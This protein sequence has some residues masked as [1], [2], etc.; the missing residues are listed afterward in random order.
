M[1]AIVMNMTGVSLIGWFH[2]LAATLSILVG[3]AVIL[4]AKGTAR[5][6]F[7]GRTYFAAMIAAN[8]SSFAVYHFDVARFVPFTAGPGIFGLF[9]WESVF[10]LAVLL[11]AFYAA[12]RQRRAVWAYVHPIAML[13]T[14]YM[15]IGGLVN[16][17]FVRVPA[18]RNLA[19]AELHGAGNPVRA[20]IAG[21]TQGAVMMIFLAMLVYFVAKVALTRR[22]TAIAL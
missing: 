3:G 16:E 5:H 20:P 17:L 13:T 18:I 7:L 8:A 6:R 14:Y 19:M 10:T 21:M 11:V 1:S 2:T 4:G 12:S 22:R 9:H 15:L